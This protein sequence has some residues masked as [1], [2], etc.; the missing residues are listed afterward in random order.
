M[1]SESGGRKR[2]SSISSAILLAAAIGVIE[3]SALILGS[4]ILLSIMGVSHVCSRISY[5]CIDA[6]LYGC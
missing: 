5:Q 4:E 3:A 6:I 2:L 1:S